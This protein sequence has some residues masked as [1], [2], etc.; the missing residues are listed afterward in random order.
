MTP[1][2]IK[3]ILAAMCAGIFL[4]CLIAHLIWPLY[5]RADATTFIR[6]GDWIM[7]NDINNFLWKVNNDYPPLAIL[8]ITFNAAIMRLF[9]MSEM[10]K[11]YFHTITPTIS[12]CVGMILIYLLLR[13]FNISQKK[14]LILSAV[15]GFNPIFIYNIIY[16]QFDVLLTM[17]ALLA[18]YLYVKQRYFWVIGVS[19]I[20]TL[21]K[22]HFAY[23]IFPLLFV[24]V[25]YQMYK[26]KKIWRLTWFIGIIGIIG[27]CAYSFFMWSAVIRGNYMHFITVLT[28][29]LLK[30]SGLSMGAFNFLYVFNMFSMQYSVQYPFWYMYINFIVLSAILATSVYFFLVK[31]TDKQLIMVLALYGIALYLFTVAMDNRYVFPSFAI[32]FLAVFIC[33]EK[34]PIYTTYLLFGMMLINNLYIPFKQAWNVLFGIK[35]AN[36]YIPDYISG[37]GNTDTDWDGDLSTDEVTNYITPTSSFEFH[38]FIG[39]MIGLL[40]TFAFLLLTLELWKSTFGTRGENPAS[41]NSTKDTPTPQ[42]PNT[43]QGEGTPQQTPPATTRKRKM[44]LPQSQS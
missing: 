25:V 43:P 34:R 3:Q 41:N 18:V 35:N 29:P 16:G 33:G 9:G 38:I 2:R 28:S 10:W 36:N 40:S 22:L 14:A 24:A 8:L 44:I 19:V 4:V 26:Q 6:W 32:L 42:S 30:R 20:A 31:P 23:F 12:L 5:F 21:T 39:G 1:R 27:I 11:Y 15:Y 37:N 7:D 13:H 17:F